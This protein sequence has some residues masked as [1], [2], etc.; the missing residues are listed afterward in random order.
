MFAASDIKYNYLNRYSN[1]EYSNKKTD[2]YFKRLV[3]YLPL[4]VQFEKDYFI[5]GTRIIDMS[6][7]KVHKNDAQLR[8][9]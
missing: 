4:T 5:I 2:W 6:D 1:K 9:I 3:Y 7:L 8:S